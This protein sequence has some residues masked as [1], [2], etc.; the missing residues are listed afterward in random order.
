LPDV[1]MPRVSGRRLAEQLAKQRPN[2]K[3]IYLSGYTDDAMV[4]HGILEAVVCFLQK[5]FTRTVLLK[6]VRDVLDS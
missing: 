2:L 5:P 1:I 6:K 4:W 3:V